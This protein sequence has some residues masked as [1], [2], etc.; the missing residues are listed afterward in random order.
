M[1]EK[2]CGIFG[3]HPDPAID[4]CIEV[5]DLICEHKSIGYG[6]GVFT[7]PELQDR[8]FKASMFRVGGVIDAINAKADLR[9]LEELSDKDLLASLPQGSDGQGEV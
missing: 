1:S 4:F 7:I 5:N 8:I 3:W 6:M 9:K 2:T